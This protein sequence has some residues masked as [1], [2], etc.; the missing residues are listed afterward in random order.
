MR[1]ISGADHAGFALEDAVVRLLRERGQDV[2]D[3]GTTVDTPFDGRRHARRLEK[4]AAVEAEEAAG[5]GC[6]SGS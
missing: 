1:I 4:V 3:V 5:A 6:R 2:V